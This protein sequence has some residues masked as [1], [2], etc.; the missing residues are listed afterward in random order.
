MQE[1]IR[2]RKIFD[3]KDEEKKIDLFQNII[4]TKMALDM[5]NAN[6]NYAEAEMIDCY[7][8]EIK[9]HKAKLDYLLKQVKENGW[10]L[11]MVNNIDLYFEENNIVG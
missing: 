2:E 9:A 5:A 4:K 1:Y 3:K 7:S 11:D 8:Y 6:F 10:E